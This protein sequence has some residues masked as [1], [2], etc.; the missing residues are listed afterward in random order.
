MIKATLIR[1]KIRILAGVDHAAPRDIMPGTLL[2][3]IRCSHLLVVRVKGDKRSTLSVYGQAMPATLAA[4]VREIGQEDNDPHALE[5]A[6]TQEPGWSALF[7]NGE[8]LHLSG[9]VPA[10]IHGIEILRGDGELKSGDVAVERGALKKGWHHLRLEVDRQTAMVMSFEDNEVRCSLLE[11]GLGHE[12]KLSMTLPNQEHDVRLRDV[13]TLAG[14]IIEGHN[15]A[16]RLGMVDEHGHP[17]RRFP[18]RE[19]DH[20]P[21]TTRFLG[22][23][24]KLRDFLKHHP[25]HFWPDIQPYWT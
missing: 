15:L 24:E 21:E 23:K 19:M 9:D 2:E 16:T 20:M 5:E 10:A 11:R 4:L 8:A 7:R 14:T 3:E 12:G 6:L 1:E 22:L 17:V 18:P 13:L 25:V